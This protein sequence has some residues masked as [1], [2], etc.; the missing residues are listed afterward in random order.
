VIDPSADTGLLG[1]VACLGFLA[2]PVGLVLRRI[3][4]Q[5]QPAKPPAA[6]APCGPAAPTSPSVDTSCPPWTAA[7]PP[8]LAAASSGH[9]EF[10]NQA[11]LR[12][13][14]PTHWLIRV[15]S[16]LT[17]LVLLL[18]G[19]MAFFVTV[20]LFLTEDNSP[21]HPGIRIAVHLVMMSIMAGITLSGIFL[22]W[23]GMKRTGRSNRC[24]A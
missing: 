18:I 21:V 22:L 20:K 7:P 12:T 16:I 3:G 2:I 6:A 4:R 17:G 10:T 14:R 24:D 5:M 8:P 11:G 15:I 9:P 1:L 23:K 19:S 13:S